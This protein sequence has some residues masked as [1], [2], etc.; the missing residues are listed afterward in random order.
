LPTLWH[1][2]LHQHLLQLWLLIF[3]NTLVGGASLSSLATTMARGP[4]ITSLAPM[5]MM[6]YLQCWAQGATSTPSAL[7][8]TSSSSTTLAWK[9]E[10]SL[11]GFGNWVT[12]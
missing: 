11:F 4:L 8:P 7:R 1:E 5:P 12:T 2:G 6:T 9:A 3:T 10:R